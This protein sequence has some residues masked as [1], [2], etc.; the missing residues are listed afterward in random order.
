MSWF[1]SNDKKNLNNSAS[2]TCPVCLS[3]GK[4]NDSDTCI[5]NGKFHNTNKIVYV[6][7]KCYDRQH[8]LCD[9]CVNKKAF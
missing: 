9:D 1:G 5:C 3:T 4:I 8:G 2:F 6:H 7:G